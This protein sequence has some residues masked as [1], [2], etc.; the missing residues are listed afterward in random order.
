MT[1][2][3]CRHNYT[4]KAQIDIINNIQI[5]DKVDNLYLVI[6]DVDFSKTGYT[7]YG[8]GMGYGN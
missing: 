5:N 4:D 2:Y 3:V 6:N 8:Y 7:G 1:I